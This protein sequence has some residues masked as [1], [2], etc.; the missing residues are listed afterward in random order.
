MILVS[1]A[2]TAV[3]HYRTF[4]KNED[5]LKEIIENNFHQISTEIYQQVNDHKVIE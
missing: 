5:H 1:L 3:E 4:A 2:Q